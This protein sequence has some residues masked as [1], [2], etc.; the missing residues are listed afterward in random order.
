MKKN[1][2][3]NY[4]ERFNEAELKAFELLCQKEGKV[5]DGAIRTV[6]KKFNVDAGELLHTKY[7]YKLSN[8]THAASS[9]IDEIAAEFEV[10]PEDIVSDLESYRESCRENLESALDKSLQLLAKKGKFIEKNIQKIADEFFVDMPKLMREIKEFVSG[11]R[12]V[13]DKLSFFRIDN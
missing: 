4:E 2:E 7:S 9:M 13:H 11:V 5:T 6:A 10:D 1:N 8:A 12:E 3:K